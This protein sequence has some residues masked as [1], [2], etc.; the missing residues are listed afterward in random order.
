MPHII[1]V[2]QQR[3]EHRSI[4][5]LIES[6]RYPRC[7]SDAGVT[8][9][10]TALFSRGEWDG[11]LIVKGLDT[12]FLDLP[13]AACYLILRQRDGYP[14]AICYGRPWIEVYT[15]P[16]LRVCKVGV[17]SDSDGDKSGQGKMRPGPGCS[18][19]IEVPT[20]PVT[21]PA[22]QYVNP[23]ALDSA[24][25]ARSCH[26]NQMLIQ[27]G[28]LALVKCCHLW[29]F[30]IVSAFMSVLRFHIDHCLLP[31]DPFL[32]EHV[33][34]LAKWTMGHSA[35]SK[36]RQRR[37]PGKRER[38]A[39]TE[40]SATENAVA[41]PEADVEGTDD[42][43]VTG[44]VVGSNTG[45]VVNEWEASTNGET[46]PSTSSSSGLAGLPLTHVPCRTD[47]GPRMDDDDDLRY[48]DVPAGGVDAEA[49]TDPPS[50]GSNR[51]A[52]GTATLVDDADVISSSSEELQTHDKKRRRPPTPPRPR[53]LQTQAHTDE[54]LIPD[55]YAGYPG[56]GPDEPRLAYLRRCLREALL[57]STHSSTD[58]AKSLYGKMLQS[59]C[60][61]RPFFLAML[62]VALDSSEC[63]SALPSR[64]AFHC[65][66]QKKRQLRLT[67]QALAIQETHWSF[68]SEWKGLA[69]HAEQE[70]C[71]T[72]AADTTPIASIDTSGQLQ[73]EDERNHFVPLYGMETGA[74]MSQDGELKAITDYF[75]GVA[76]SLDIN[77]AFDLILDMYSDVTKRTP[78]LTALPKPLLGTGTEGSLMGALLGS[79][80]TG[81]EGDQRQ[82]KWQKDQSKGQN[83]KG[84]GMMNGRQKRPFQNGQQGGGTGT[85][86]SGLVLSPDTIQMLIKLLLRHE[87]QLATFRLSTAWVFFLSAEKPVEI[88][89]TLFVTATQWKSQ[90]LNDPGSLSNPMRV[91]L[92][93]ATWKMLHTRT[94]NIRTKEDARQQAIEMGLYDEFKGFPYQTWNAKEKKAQI[95][96]SKDPLPLDKVLELTAELMKLAVGNGVVT[97]YHCTR[98]LTEDMKGKMTTWLMEVGLRDSRCNRIWEI[99][100]V[101]K[102]NASLKLIG[103]AIREER[104]QRTPL[105]Q[106]LAQHLMRQPADN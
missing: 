93:Q 64:Q 59:A 69:S 8:G 2:M 77:K 88:I 38:Q 102:G 90:K 106:T 30:G 83:G 13:S 101:L 71:A 47:H 39:A 50:S 12:A 85:S 81:Q 24:I 40:P 10:D 66:T 25:L 17:P 36:R 82:A 1:A 6:D 42:A 52:E 89:E 19:W 53:A 60:A 62:A 86:S 63:C 11:S 55:D 74:L 67:V 45:D 95:D 41:P 68:T 75:R 76:L 34:S 33:I 84:R 100:A 23:H 43:D 105:A 99:L 29:P 70:T 16:E 65:P 92:F 98:P 9:A 28:S 22:K 61:Q 56:Q 31:K 49:V 54:E 21:G 37:R 35:A 51:V 48:R 26:I 103:G 96:E 5:V 73:P 15:S 72:W 7:R 94:E 4:A 91:I 44:D 58:W 79:T 3:L 80:G 78:V 20:S 27:A 32:Q 14:Y 104:L 87:D 18:N 97:R 57:E 46:H